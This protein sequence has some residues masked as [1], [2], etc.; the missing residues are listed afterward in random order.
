MNNSK[1]QS[2]SETKG[3]TNA[4]GSYAGRIYAASRFG[5]CQKRKL[6][7]K[8]I[9]FSFRCHR[10]A[11]HYCPAHCWLTMSCC[12][13]TAQQLNF[14]VADNWPQG[15][16]TPFFW[17]VHFWCAARNFNLA[18]AVGRKKH[19][20]DRNQED[21][22]IWSLQKGRANRGRTP[23]FPYFQRETITRGFS[24]SRFEWNKKA[25][26]R[27]FECGLRGFESRRRTAPS[28]HFPWCKLHW[29]K[30]GSPFPSFGA[31]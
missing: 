1:G 24:A 10:S 18:V 12:S 14:P 15:V 29:N 9:I 30:S 23:P 22:K 16:L 17:L 25:V 19:Q 3:H 26:S 28:F 31:W 7:W 2:F 11:F 8:M 27:S 20:V 6:H 21:W 5:S 4:T 13:S